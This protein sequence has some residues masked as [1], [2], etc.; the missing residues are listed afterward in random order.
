MALSTRVGVHLLAGQI[1]AAASLIQEVQTIGEATG[2]HFAPYGALGI[3]VGQGREAD[4]VAVIE[5]NVDE[6]VRRG[7]G[8]GVSLIHWASALLYNGLARHEEALVAAQ[9]ATEHPDD[10]L[11]F[12][13]GLIEL[14][15]AVARVGRPSSPPT[16]SGGCR[17][18]AA[19]PA[20]T[21]RWASERVRVR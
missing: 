1:A 2:S 9:R 12:N 7:E 19:P 4:A 10:L 8:V 20:A 17:R 11:F 16:R 13:W 14:V 21:G 3:A 15:E 6:M 5:A 18:W